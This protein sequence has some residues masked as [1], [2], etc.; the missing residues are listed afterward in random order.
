MKKVFLLAV[1]LMISVMAHAQFSVQLGYQMNSMKTTFNDVRATQYYNGVSAVIDY[2]IP[3]AGPLSVAPGLGLGCYFTNK[4]DVKYREL[5][6]IAPIDLNFCVSERRDLSVSIFAGPTFYYGLFCKDFSVNPPY[7]YYD[8]EDQRFD[9]SLGGGIWV[10]I[11]EVF[12]VKLG[13]KAGLLNCSKEKGVTE[14]NNTLTLAIGY[15]F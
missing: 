8:S 1:A 2:N 6:I 15:L 3:L 4:Y 13:Y 10:D 12:R 11:S 7:N 14:K 9:V 5:G